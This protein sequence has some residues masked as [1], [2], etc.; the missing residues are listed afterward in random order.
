MRLLLAFALIAAQSLPA[1]A[2][3]GG[4]A[5]AP[6]PIARAVVV[7]AGAR[8][9]CSG[10]A[11]APDL[12]LTAAHCV[13]PGAEYKIVE[14]GAGREPHLRDIARIIAHP[15]FNPAFA[16]AHRATADV[17]LLKLAAPLSR[18]APARLHGGG[19]TVAPGDALTVAGSGVT[20]P[21]DGRSGG[22]AR[23]AQLVATG[24]PGTL[25]IRL[26]DPAT[27]NERAGLG[28]CTGDSGGPVFGATEGR[29]A[30]I[31]VISWSTAA[32]NAGGC[33]GLTGVTPLT[34]YLEWIRSTAKILRNQL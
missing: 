29:L 32:K 12:A 9:F 28:A 1:C 25:Q 13:L 22:V 14:Y 31:G 8:G 17:A 5:P 4:A 33:G 30:V 11:L 10:V 34:L 23:A 21:G 26:L 20:A 27:R 2:L 15:K 6:E 19:F 18:A 7:F 3:V 24:Q 16:A